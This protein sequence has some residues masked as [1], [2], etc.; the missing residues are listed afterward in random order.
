ME[1]TEQSRKSKDVFVTMIKLLGLEGEVEDKKNGKNII[2]SVNTEQPGRL[3]GK[4]GSSLESLGLLMNRILKKDEVDFPRV[5]IDVDGYDRNKKNNRNKKR[6]GRYNNR[7]NKGGGRYNN[8]QQDSAGE[9]ENNERPERS[10]RQQ[11]PRNNRR[12]NNNRGPRQEQQAEAAEANAVEAAAPV[13]VAAAPAAAQA[14]QAPVQ[15][16]E[17]KAEKQAQDKPRAERQD[18]PKKQ[19]SDRPKKENKGPDGKPMSRLQMM[20]RNAGKEVKRWGEPSFLPPMSE[21]ECYKAID[22]LKEDSE[23]IATIDDS[24]N[25]GAKKRVKVELK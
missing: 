20:C 1:S 23:L 21:S 25:Y 4:N 24:R 19:R 5:I 9:G 16:S 2:L 22:C 18:R 10:E 3:I 17:P 13:E 8:R 12:R 6:G 14:P 7:N 11:K 15:Q